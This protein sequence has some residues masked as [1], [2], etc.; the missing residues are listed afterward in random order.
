[1]WGTYMQYGDSL[2]PNLIYLSSHH[3]NLNLG[4]RN[5][6][7]GWAI[8]ESLSL[9]SKMANFKLHCLTRGTTEVRILIKDLKNCHPVN[10]HLVKVSSKEANI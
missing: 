3:L 10:R 9:P 5:T 8:E 4:K 1:M 2:K 7:I 6:K